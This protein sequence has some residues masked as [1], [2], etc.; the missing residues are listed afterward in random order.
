MPLGRRRSKNVCG[1]AD[2]ATC[3][4]LQN[5]AGTAKIHTVRFRGAGEGRTAEHLDVAKTPTRAARPAAAGM[6]AGRLAGAAAD[7]QPIAFGHIDVDKAA[8]LHPAPTGGRAPS[9][10]SRHLGRGLRQAPHGAG[11]GGD[12]QLQPEDSG[13]EA[14]GSVRGGGRTLQQAAWQAEAA[15]FG[16]QPGVNQY[17]AA[18]A[19]N[20]APP[21]PI[22][23]FIATD[24]GT[25]RNSWY[26]SPLFYQERLRCHDTCTV[27]H[28]SSA[29]H[30]TMLFSGIALCPY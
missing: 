1:V 23:L 11:G 16:G 3:F 27:K 17:G 4:A 2:V 9:R 21:F 8:A 14:G 22:D 6:A 20:S 26:M 29:A 28:C 18:W 10:P 15:A 12:S 7:A 30:G 5:V 25:V 24:Q 13:G 19:V